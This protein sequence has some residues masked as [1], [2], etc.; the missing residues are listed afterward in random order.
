MYPRVLPRLLAATAAPLLTLVLVAATSREAHAEPTSW[1]AVGGGVSVQRNGV[2]KLNDAAGAVSASIGVGTSADHALVVGGIFRTVT[3][4]N[5]GTDLGLGARFASRGFCRGDFGV[6]LDL[7]VVGRFWEQGRYGEYPLQAVVT[8]GV[9]WGF[10]AAIGAQAFNLSGSPQAAGGFFVVELD[11]LRL[12]VM[13]QGST[14]SAWPNVAPAGG[15]PK[16]V[17]TT[18]GV[19]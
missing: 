3:H 7:G 4:W 10:Q 9:P 19:D 13:R 14:T 17:S 8:V 11:L 15:V 2:A 1:L 18:P 5:L 6:A 16:P 12:T